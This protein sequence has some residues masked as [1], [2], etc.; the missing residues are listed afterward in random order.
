M[1]EILKN[2]QAYFR[3][4]HL[5]EQEDIKHFISSKDFGNMSLFKR[6]NKQQVVENRR[7]IAKVLETDINNFVFQQQV[8]GTQCPVITKQDKGKGVYSYAS[9]I[10]DNDAMITREKGICLI[11]MAGDCAPLLFYDPKQK[12]IGVAHAGWRGTYKK[13][14]RK[15]I[16]KMINNFQSDP[17]DILA[18]IGPS[19]SQK[20][21]EV[22]DLVYNEFKKHI[23]G[24]QTFFSKGKEKGKYYLD[25]WAANKEQLLQSGLK[26]EN[27]EISGL[28]TYQQNHF[29][30]SARRGE[31]GRFMAGIMIL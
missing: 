28:C 31:A 20:H 5:S 12:V 9:A 30:Y 26:E 15:T 17:G 4:E 8:H 19:I 14:A 27:I 13:I 22:D 10:K 18:G 16:E 25:L 24:F 7:Q 6:K 21:Y 29:F 23:S 1:V 2:G 11:A 3:F